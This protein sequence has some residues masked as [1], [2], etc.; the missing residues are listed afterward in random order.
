[1]SCFR[2]ALSLALVASEMQVTKDVDVS[3][4]EVPVG[5]LGI[6]TDASSGLSL[7]LNKR[8]GFS[9]SLGDSLFHGLL[10]LR[11][12]KFSVFV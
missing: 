5:T 1:M 6:A 4:D 3:A 11:L 7:S 9:R 2:T 12:C 8:L 10:L